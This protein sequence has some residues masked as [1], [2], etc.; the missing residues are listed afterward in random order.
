MQEIGFEQTLKAVYAAAQSRLGPMQ[1]LEKQ[2][3]QLR[4]QCTQ[5]EIENEHYKTKVE[6]LE[7]LVADVTAEN[8]VLKVGSR[9]DDL[10]TKKK[11][12]KIRQ[13]VAA[14]YDVSDDDIISPRRSL[15]IL[16]PRKVAIYLCKTLTLRSLPEIGKFFGNR[17]HTTI[18]HSVRFITEHRKTDL[19]LDEELTELESRLRS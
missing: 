12:I 7:R 6:F 16:R 18:L 4:V 11:I 5:L 10:P 17:D 8:N 14:Y 3:R 15:Y 19:G 9:F 2:V 13:V 1:S